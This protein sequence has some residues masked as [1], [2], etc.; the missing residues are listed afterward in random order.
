[1]ILALYEYY[2]NQINGEY[3]GNTLRNHGILIKRSSLIAKFS[4]SFSINDS[5]C[6]VRV[7]AFRYYHIC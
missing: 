2:N 5:F 7:K 3:M 6:S 1:M 4:L